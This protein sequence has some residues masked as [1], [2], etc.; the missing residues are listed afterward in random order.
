V[1]TVC[2]KLLHPFAP[3]ITEELWQQLREG[4]EG[5]EPSI[6]ISVWPTPGNR[7]AV[8]EAE[9]QRVADL[10]Q[11]IRRLRS[12]Y[13]VDWSRRAPVTIEALDTPQ[14]FKDQSVAI[15]SLARLDPLEVVERV[16]EEPSDALTVVAGGVRA[17]VAA[18]GLFDVDGELKRLTGGIHTTTQAVERKEALLGRE[19]FVAKA[20]PAV[21]E[22]ERRDLEQLRSELAL[23]Q[24]QLSRLQGMAGG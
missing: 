5:L 24:E 1:F 8:A 12:E 3:F 17:F 11:G 7:D 23:M 22:R 2:L 21:V 13:R 10:I 4:Q 19:G 14:L 6:M 20:P 15:A 9:F 16:R 18:S